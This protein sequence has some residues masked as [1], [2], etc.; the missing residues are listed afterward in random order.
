MEKIV[1]DDPRGKA[2][3]SGKVRDDESIASHDV[4]QLKIQVQH[5][6]QFCFTLRCSPS[7]KGNVSL[8]PTP[9]DHPDFLIV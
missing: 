3:Q 1:D 4:E 2:T 8:Q 6:S 5:K 9:S 7:A